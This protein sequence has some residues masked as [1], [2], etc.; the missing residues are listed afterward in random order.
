LP[1][2]SPEG[3]DSSDSEK[4]E[5]SSDSDKSLAKSKHGTKGNKASLASS[6]QKCR[7]VDEDCVSAKPPP[8][9]KAKAKGR[10]LPVP[11]NDEHADDDEHVVDVDLDADTGYPLI[12]ARLPQ[13]AICKAIALGEKT[14]AEATKIGKE[15]GKPVRTILIEAGLAV[16]AVRAENSWNMYQVWYKTMHLKSLNGEYHA[17]HIEYMT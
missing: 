14:V 11:T 1:D 7:P 8:T 16:K 3:S 15:Y 17:G 9:R 4:S 10:E 6:S 12:P 13:E 5:L 2:F